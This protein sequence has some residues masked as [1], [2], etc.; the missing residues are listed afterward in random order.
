MKTLPI[1]T[2]SDLDG[3]LGCAILKE[4]GYSGEIEF[5]NP[6]DVLNGPCAVSGRCV[7]VNLPGAG[8]DR[9]DRNSWG[10]EVPQGKPVTA[11]AGILET[12]NDPEMYYRFASWLADLEKWQTR[13]LAFNDFNTPSDALTLAVVCDPATGLGR[14]RDF[15]VSNYFFLLDLIDQL[16]LQPAEIL[17][18]L[19]DV[20][21]RLELLASRKTSHEEQMKRTI[22]GSGLLL[23]QDMRD[24][25]R[26]E[27]GNPM[28]KHLLAPPH[29]AILT[30][31]WDKS[32]RKVSVALSGALN[33]EPV[34]HL[35]SLLQPFGGGGDRFSGIA[36]VMPEE[37]EA[38]IMNLEAHLQA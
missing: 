17:V 2:R 38:L 28:V 12:L 3:L 4:A 27:P 8:A 30:L 35:G 33:Q 9:W 7:R 23:I 18:R 37:I 10:E 34:V 32:R 36:Q 25:Y 20:R 14:Y 21:D 29:H 1:Y 22:K 26:I 5:L 11:S 31:Y 15:I 6:L 19:G 24:E 13:R 16:R